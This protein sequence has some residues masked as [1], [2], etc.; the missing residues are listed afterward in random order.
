MWIRVAIYA[1]LGFAYGQGLD[2]AAL[3]VGM[4]GGRIYS[5]MMVGPSWLMEYIIVGIAVAVAL[6]ERWRWMWIVGAVLLVIHVG[7]ALCFA[8]TVKLESTYD[9]YECFAQRPV[10]CTICVLYYGL[11]YVALG[12]C[13]LRRKKGIHAPGSAGTQ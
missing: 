3:F 4:S 1:I 11:M 8:V 10:G 5:T 2:T 6:G 9:L 12:M 13:Y 7:Y